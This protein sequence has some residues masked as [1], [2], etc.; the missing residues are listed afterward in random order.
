MF[1]VKNKNAERMVV[2]DSPEFLGS[3][4]APTQ[5]ND[6]NSTKIATTAWVR[7]AM[8]KIMTALGFVVSLSVNGYIKLPSCLGGL[9]IQWGEATSSSSTYTLVTFPISFTT[10]CLTAYAT[11]KHDSTMTSTATYAIGLSGVTT[12]K[13]CVGIPFSQNGSLVSSAFR[14]LAIGY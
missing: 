13:L 12:T 4:K 6:D 3:P 8:A 7:N 9:I 1:S 11:S 10:S 14:W 2:M 5:S